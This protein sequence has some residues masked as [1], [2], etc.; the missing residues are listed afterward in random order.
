MKDP[1]KS[2]QN[3]HKPQDN[4]HGHIGGGGQSSHPQTQHL[5]HHSVMPNDL[6]L[7]LGM[8]V[9]SN[10]GMMGSMDKVNHDL[11]KAVSSKVNV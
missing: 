11:I 10:L 2:A 6:K 3:L 1:H 4:S 8:G 9:G 7:N 5:S